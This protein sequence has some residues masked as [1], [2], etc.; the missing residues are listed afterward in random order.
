M[1]QIILPLIIVAILFIVIIAGMPNEFVLMRSAK[2]SAPP[3]KI[4][5]YVNDLHKWDA[6]SPWAKLD[7]NAKYNFEGPPTGPGSSM[8]WDGNKKIG[9][10]K[11]TI[12]ES[13]PST[14]IR[15]R[16]EFLRP[17]A[18]TN[19]AEFV[20]QPM[21]SQTN[22]AWSMIGKTNFGFKMFGLFVN[23]DDMAGRDFERGLASLKS[24]TETA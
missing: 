22:V 24:L 11:M 17:F 15:F 10:G 20:I 12:T 14:F 16:L 19:I 8:S 3:E 9:A 18:A 13:Q 2:I 23:C 6:W 1:F 5:P 21:G 7:A 4:F